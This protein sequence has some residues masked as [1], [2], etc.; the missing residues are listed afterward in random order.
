MADT[1]WNR[2]NIVQRVSYYIAKNDR[3]FYIILAAALIIVI[4][5]VAAV[6]GW[7]DIENYWRSAVNIL[8]GDWDNIEG[9][10]PPLF[11]AISLIPAIF[12][13]S[14]E[15]YS[16]G[17]TIM[18]AIFIMISAYFAVKICKELKQEQ[19]IAYYGFFL[20]MLCL[21]VFSISRNDSIT[22]AFVISAFYFLLKKSYP[23]AFIL[24]SL[25]IMIKIFPLIFLPAFL[26]PFILDRKWKHFIGY[27]VLTVAICLLIQLPMFFINP[28]HALDYIL[29]HSERGLQ[30]EAVAAGPLMLLQL[31]FPDAMHY[32]LSYGSINIVGAVPDA[33]AKVLLPLMAIILV[34][35][36]FFTI[37][38]LWK[39]KLDDEKKFALVSVFSMI[40]VFLFLVLNKVYSTQYNVWIFMLLS[41]WI[42]G[43][44]IMGF[45]V[46]KFS[47]FVFIF[48]L[49]CLVDTFTYNYG[50]DPYVIFMIVTLVKAVVLII[51]LV[52]A[53]KMFFKWM[54][55]C[56]V[57]N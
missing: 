18:S 47:F 12:S 32:E 29:Q 44:K 1:D 9:A 42:V 45:D 40:C 19:R 17:F 26:L 39:T 57:H 54:N 36:F 6:Q 2:L 27:A 37:Y 14:Y 33:I 50:G 56:K 4:T 43:L 22:M 52:L 35:F 16:V 8:N 15:G 23:A 11:L 10:Y 13:T 48:G 49:I 28:D 3:N 30:I 46:S 31:A 7:G 41:T 38:K 34:A 55:E 25:G 53:T 24:L 20:L 21:C 5:A 51:L